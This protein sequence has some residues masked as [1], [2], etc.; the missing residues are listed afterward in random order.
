MTKKCII[1]D[2]EKESEVV[3]YLPLVLK[4]L[5]RNPKDYKNEIDRVKSDIDMGFNFCIGNP[6]EAIYIRFNYCPYCGRKLE[7]AKGDVE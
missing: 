4:R 1:C 3:T 7:Q 6:G 2:E 5:S